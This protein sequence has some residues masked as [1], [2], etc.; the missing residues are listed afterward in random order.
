VRKGEIAF[1]RET[2]ALQELSFVDEP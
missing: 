1:L 2:V